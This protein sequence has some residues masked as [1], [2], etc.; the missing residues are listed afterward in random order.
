MAFHVHP[1]QQDKWDFGPVLKKITNPCKR[2][3]V[4]PEIGFLTEG[5]KTPHGAF[6]FE[7][8][9][10]CPVQSCEFYLA[11]FSPGEWNE[12]NPIDPNQ[13]KE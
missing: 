5:T 9:V 1:Y 2:H 13:A 11:E 4:H 7:M 12:R 6:V 3:G 8:R 10:H